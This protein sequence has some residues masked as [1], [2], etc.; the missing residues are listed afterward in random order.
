[1]LHLPDLHGSAAAVSGTHQVRN[2]SN[3]GHPTASSYVFTETPVS[4]SSLDVFFRWLFDKE[5]LADATVR[6]EYVVFYLL[7]I[8]FKDDYF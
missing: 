2:R 5:F 1:M 8:T 4:V 6:F 7:L 3:V